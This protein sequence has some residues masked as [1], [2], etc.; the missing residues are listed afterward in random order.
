MLNGD[1][2]SR[3]ILHQYIDDIVAYILSQ[4]ILTPIKT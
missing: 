3:L 2:Q 4:N 1:E